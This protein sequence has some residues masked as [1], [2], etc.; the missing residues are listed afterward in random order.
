MKL[1]VGLIL[2]A[3]WFFIK[4]TTKQETFR[5]TNT[6]MEPSLTCR[7]FCSIG[8]LSRYAHDIPIGTRFSS[9]AF[10]KACPEWSLGK[11]H[12]VGWIIVHQASNMP[13]K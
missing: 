8:R 5:D 1:A 2:E 6:L 3:V 7:G 9:A 10:Y 11:G 12:P 13:T 4:R